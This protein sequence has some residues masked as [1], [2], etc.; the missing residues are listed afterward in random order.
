MS[1]NQHINVVENYYNVLSNIEKSAKKVGRDPSEITLVGVT[2]RIEV[3]RIVPVLK[4]GLT[5]IGEIVGKDLKQKYELLKH[6]NVSIH[7]I[8]KLQSNKVKYAVEKCDLVQSVHNEKILSLINKRAKMNKRV[9]PI[10]LQVDF[11]NLEVKK[12]LNLE[13]TK[14]IIHL[15]KTKYNFVQ[16]Q[17]FMTIAPLQY[18]ENRRILAKFFK[19]TREYVDKELVPKIEYDNLQLSMGMTDAYQLAIENGSTMV[20]VGTAIFGPRNK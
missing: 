9:F 3:Q 10:F 17:G 13:E 14:N 1:Q 2:K 11:S 12:G 4:E 8:G 16:I 7:V 6:N 5:T 18:M 19:K 20:R 15:I